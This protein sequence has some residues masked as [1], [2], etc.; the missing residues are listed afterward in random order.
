MAGV[1]ALVAGLGAAG[2]FLGSYPPT[3]TTSQPGPIPD[4]I[5]PNSLNV[6]HSNQVDQ[7]NA[8][9]VNESSK[10]WEQSAA[11]GSRMI[12][13]Q[14]NSLGRP[15][16][17]DVVG[18]LGAVGQFE[19]NRWLLQQNMVPFFRGLQQRQPVGQL[20]APNPQLERFTQDSS[21]AVLYKPPKQE[22]LSMYEL[23]KQSVFP[24]NQ[25]NQYYA[26]LNQAKQAVS[27]VSAQGVPL[28]EPVHVGPGLTGS[29][30]AEPSGGRHPMFRP[31]FKTVNELRA[32]SDK[33]KITMRG[34]VLPGQQGSK[35]GQV[36]RVAKERPE[37]AFR[38]IDPVPTRSEISGDMAK[39]YVTDPTA[40]PLTSRVMRRPTTATS[41]ELD[42]DLQGPAAMAAGGREGERSEYVM[43]PARN[44]YLEDQ[45]GVG[46][47]GKVSSRRPEQMTLDDFIGSKW[48]QPRPIVENRLANP[49]NAL[50]GSAAPVYDPD[51]VYQT[52][53]RETNSQIPIQ[54]TVGGLGLKAS[55]GQVRLPL[56]P[57]DRP[58]LTNRVTIKET[59]DDRGQVHGPV[60][61]GVVK[62]P[63]D[64]PE[65]TGRAV[66]TQSFDDRG[67]VHGPIS[68]GVVKDPND[69][70]VL[71]M[72]GDQDVDPLQQAMPVG[73]SAAQVNQHDQDFVVTR[74]Q[75]VET[76]AQAS[77]MAG[78]MA[79]PVFKGRGA[80]SM[81]GP[82][83]D[84]EDL[85]AFR[86]QDGATDGMPFTVT[87][88]QQPGKGVAH[89]RQV[90]T[91]IKPRQSV[92]VDYQGG[93][94]QDRGSGYMAAKWEQRY[95]QRQ[96]MS[97]F[98]FK[99]GKAEVTQGNAPRSSGY[100]LD[101]CGKKEQLLRTQ[102]P[103]LSGAKQNLNT[104]DIRQ[105][106][107][108]QFKVNST[109]D[110]VQLPINMGAAIQTTSSQPQQEDTAIRQSQSM[111][112][113]FLLP[114]GNPFS[115]V[116]GVSSTPI[117]TAR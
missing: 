41:G 83:K 28:N 30:E 65:L 81:N 60:A 108:Q 36:G 21:D 98:M 105:G 7:A 16:Q 97:N 51:D 24:G 15:N 101:R 110:A 77:A 6:F 59:F 90:K 94:H 47:T 96:Q 33:Q 68:R 25:P 2:K 20:D 14:F 40:V 38:P 66:Q 17:Q 1:F 69:R 93:A 115:N 42:A 79:H 13:D 45:H 63:N 61:R 54:H 62:D 37:T 88:V 9:T 8:K 35:R 46:Q 49:H 85:P 27:R 103:T 34:R 78:G 22:V 53:T 5:Q 18:P 71:T 4:S 116:P 12:P 89:D 31:T 3:T 39:T 104:Q 48:A 82:V 19:Q 10:R 76:L 43:G 73:P 84:P 11:P 109:R 52:T 56:A 70:P 57:D 86:Q 112:S 75:Q 74:R 64:R 117:Q 92:L 107:L 100:Q 80:V 95:T 113:R 102:A 67:Q 72:R 114:V 106:K 91:W 23:Q 50:T 29:F 111:P 58:E 32:V 44:L 26:N 99:P 55:Q 87:T